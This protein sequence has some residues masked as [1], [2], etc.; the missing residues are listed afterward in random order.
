MNAK[1]H[2][3][4]AM[5]IL[6]TTSMLNLASA[7]SSN[8]PT[9]PIGGQ[10]PAGSKPSVKDLDYQLKYQRAFEAVLWGIP[11]V[12]IYGFEK[13]TRALGFEDN[14]ILAFSAPAR[15]KAELLT[16]NTVT[17]YILAFT[18]L[19]NGP[20]VLELP[21][22]SED[23]SLFGQVVDHWQITIADVGPSGVDKGKGGKLLLTPPA[24]TSAKYSGQEGAFVKRRFMVLA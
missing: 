2:I 6:M 22:A 24:C 23:A 1:R 10:P 15:Q 7:Q 12:A 4:I 11:A 21:P 19:R 13:G 16:A 14:V 20:A 3:T 9:D 8:M 18:D 5:T 17:P